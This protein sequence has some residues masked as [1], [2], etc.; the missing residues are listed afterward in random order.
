MN[1]IFKLKTKISSSLLFI[2][3]SPLTYLTDATFNS[4]LDG[5]GTFEDKIC[6]VN[7][8][9]N[10]QTVERSDLPEHHFKGI[11]LL[12]TDYLKST[13]LILTADYAN[14]KV[15]LEKSKQIINIFLIF[16]LKISY[17]FLKFK[18]RLETWDFKQCDAIE[19]ALTMISDFFHYNYFL[20][21]HL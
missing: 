21:F 19:T 17:K 20:L 2:K 11:N 13:S 5:K 8:H 1:K 16:H 4:L 12:G 3:A 9:G 15:K 10:R 14:D 6:E 18:K 7:I